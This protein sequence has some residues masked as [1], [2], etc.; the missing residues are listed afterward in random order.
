[1][2]E[3]RIER[4][5]K[6]SREKELQFIVFL[7]EN[8]TRKD[9]NLAGESAGLSFVGSMVGNYGQC[10][11]PIRKI[12]CIISII[13]SLVNPQSNCGDNLGRWLDKNAPGWIEFIPKAEGE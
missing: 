7:D 11:P 12:S 5:L 2:N 6:M 4:C 3:P 1:M 8:L 10:P 9:L 13:Q